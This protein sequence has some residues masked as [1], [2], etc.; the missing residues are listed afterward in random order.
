MLLPDQFHFVLVFFALLGSGLIAGVF[1]A[2]SAF[3]MKALVRLTPADGIA[4][5]QSINITVLNPWF[6]G[7]FLGTA[8]ICI[9][10][11]VW[12]LLLWNQNGS[13]YLIMGSSFYLIGNL[14]VTAIFNVPKNE[15]L[16]KVNVS[17][18]DADQLWRNYV[19]KWTYWNHV[20]TVASLLAAACFGLSL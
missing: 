12:T 6:L 9:L 1:F 16:A 10:L 11:L 7:V 8:V 15:A 17:D 14:M 5:M 3:V 19:D 18:A 20:R 2:F 4:A 13:M